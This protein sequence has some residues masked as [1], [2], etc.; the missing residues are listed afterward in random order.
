LKRWEKAV[1]WP[2]TTS[3]LIFLAAYAVPIIN[4]DLPPGLEH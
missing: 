3:A 1:D 2:L 4:P